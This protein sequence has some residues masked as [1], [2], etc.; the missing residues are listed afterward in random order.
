MSRDKIFSI[1]TIAGVILLTYTI[2]LSVF[3]KT[4]SMLSLPSYIILLGVA[5]IILVIFAFLLIIDK[6]HINLGV[7]EFIICLVIVTFL[8]RI[9]WVLLIDTAPV[10]DFFLYH[11]Y[12]TKA[13]QGLYNLYPETY[14]LFPFKFGY[15]LLLSVLYRIFG[16]SLMTAKLLNVF[17]SVIVAILI[18]WIG[19]KV[20]TEKAGRS[21]GLIFA[22]WPAQIMYSS[23]LASEH[24]F[25]VFF[26]AA[27]AL[28]VKTQFYIAGSLKYVIPALIGVSLALAHMIR[29]VSSMLFPVLIFYMFIFVKNTPFK[30]T[31]INKFRVIALMI[32]GFAL[33]MAIFN[34]AVA[35]LTGVEVWRSSSGFS[36]LVG[37]NYQSSGMYSTE[38]EKII[39]E[40]NYD[41]DSIHKE[42]TKRAFERIKTN[43][44]NFLRLVE[45][46]FIV[47]WTSEDFGLLWSINKVLDRTPIF[48]MIND[49]SSWIE[50]MVQLFYIA[51]LLFATAGFILSKKAGNY[52]STIF[53]MLFGAFVAAHTLL[54]VQSRYHYPVIPV[55]IVVAGYGLSELYKKVFEVKLVKDL[56]NWSNV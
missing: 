37:T 36:L 30:K 17:I 41:F 48:E 31:L 10:S 39:S 19:K 7:P 54:E 21:A 9:T 11:D 42:A 13:S 51:L 20:F 24:V 52:I 14:P 33:S 44:L 32:A 22:L 27:I 40:F 56:K 4:T 49:G 55:L 15:P 46:K 12:A 25:I 28:F 18:Y 34:A 35:N 43:P 3:V 53:L 47:Q 23:V 26:A 45:K 6:F 1:G 29:P 8:P 38:D 50:L 16:G 2:I 5:I